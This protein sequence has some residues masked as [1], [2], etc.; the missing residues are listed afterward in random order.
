MARGRMLNNSVSASLKFHQLPDDTCR[1]MATWLISHLDYN[2]VFYG[3]PAMV[4][5]AIFPR[6]T[7]I[8]TE[9]I[10]QY[11][12][13]M[14]DAGLIVL[15]DANGDRWQYWPGFTH[16][17]VGLRPEKEAQSYYADPPVDDTEP[18]QSEDE[19][20][21]ETG[22]TEDGNVTPERKGTEKKGIQPSADAKKHRNARKRPT[23][24]PESRAMFSALANLC[25]IN[26]QTLTEKQRGILNQ[27][28]AK[29]RA[30][31]IAVDDLTAFSAWWYKYDWR[32]RGD[33]KQGRP[34]VPPAPHQV[35]E[36]WGKF[37][38]WNGGQT[39]PKVIKVG[40]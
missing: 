2:G 4:K 21:T 37:E 30:A 14:Q 17:Q 3:D 8:S 10:E 33:E 9:Q 16:N 22:R 28:E 6:R 34:P 7:D 40:Q 31:G 12:N 23:N 32:G 26:L 13:A 19:Q 18:G 29:L 11:L 5:S 25:Q 39:G 15:F 20:K 35:R 1:L 36:E 24:T 27:N 38:K